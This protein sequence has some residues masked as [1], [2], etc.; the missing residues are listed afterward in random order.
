M[1]FFLILTVRGAFYR[2]DF[3]CKKNG[4]TGLISEKTEALYAELNK[5]TEALYAELNKKTEALFAELNK[6]TEALYA[7]LNK[8]ALFAELNKRAE[9]TEA[10]FAELNKR[11]DT[12]IIL[13]FLR[14][15]YSAPVTKHHQNNRSRC[16][17]QEFLFTDIF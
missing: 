1:I 4:G 2:K 5:K 15:I 17:I 11:A 13:Y 16:L 8:R 6:K 7:E 12:T 10:L 9:K 14:Y 3:K